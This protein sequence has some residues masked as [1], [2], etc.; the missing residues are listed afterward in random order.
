MKVAH[1]GTKEDDDAEADAETEPFG[2]R[3]E[4]GAEDTAALLPGLGLV[5]LLLD[6]R[7]QLIGAF[8]AL[9]T[10]LA[11]SCGADVRHCCPMQTNSPISG[12]FREARTVQYFVTHHR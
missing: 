10:S 8:D 7:D 3:L 2:R 12:S 1:S 9:L 6:G 5:L 4:A 11:H